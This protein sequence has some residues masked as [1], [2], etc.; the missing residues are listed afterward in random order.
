MSVAAA[1]PALAS[2][3][4]FLVGGGEMG[5]LMRSLDW[6]RTAL[7][8]VESWPQSLRT[9][10]STCLNCAF[11]ILLWWGNDLT[12]L[13]NDAYVPVLGA[14]HP[15]AMGQRG[16]ECWPEIWDAVGPML[17]HVLETGH[18]TCSRD[19]PL[20][21]NRDGR[22]EECYFSLS[23]SPIRDETGG[24][25]GVFTP[26]IETTPNVLAAPEA[27][28]RELTCARNYGSLFSAVQ[29]LSP[30][31]AG[32]F[33]GRACTL[34]LR[35]EVHLRVVHSLVRLLFSIDSALA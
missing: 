34:F 29:G 4:D 5:A 32:G 30:E 20:V 16:E 1:A 2:D 8:P 18:A 25:G 19:V 13:Y 17:R 11:P 35:E 22:D 3:H 9:S 31:A 15:A 23:Y 33:G 10:A 21:L 12:M 24:V 28:F 6:S 7:G 14:K 27:V 26:V